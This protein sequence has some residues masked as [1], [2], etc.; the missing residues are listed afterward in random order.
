MRAGVERRPEGRPLH[1]FFCT[2]VITYILVIA[3]IAATTLVPMSFDELTAE[4]SVVVHG[5]VIDAHGVWNPER[6]AIETLV[7][8]QPLE[9][10][11]GSIAGDVTLT[12]PGGDVGRYRYVVVGAPAFAIGDEVVLFLRT[13]TASRP[14]IVGFNQGV[15][16]VTRDQANMAR[17]R[18]VPLAQFAAN[19]RARASARRQPPERRP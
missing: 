14:F 9:T 6:R 5:H 11:K 2:G 7:T 4:A 1:R 13:A 8:I 18:G 3:P 16:R 10:F 12:V 17:V 19:V 15:F